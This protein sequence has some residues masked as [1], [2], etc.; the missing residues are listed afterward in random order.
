MEIRMSEPETH[1]TGNVTSGVTLDALFRTRRQADL[2]IEQLVQDRGVERTDIFVSAE[3]SESS[4]GAEAD[5]ADVESGHPGVEMRK[6]PS[7]EGDI[8]VSVDLSDAGQQAE[9]SALLQGLEA[10]SVSAR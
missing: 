9:I 4:S 10:V 6:E 3:G 5:G 8:L 1:D 2:A 7:L